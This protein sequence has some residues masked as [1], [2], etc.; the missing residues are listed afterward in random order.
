M[1]STISNLDELQSEKIVKLAFLTFKRLVFFLS[2][3]AK[4]FSLITVTANQGRETK[5]FV[6]VLF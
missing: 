1:T 6:L 5:N 2:F 3:L 4:C